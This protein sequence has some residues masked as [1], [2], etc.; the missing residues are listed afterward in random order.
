MSECTFCNE[1]LALNAKFCKF[2]GASQ[3]V[4]LPT[5]SD[6]SVVINEKLTLVCKKCNNE[7]IP[8]AKFCK[9]CGTKVS[10][11]PITELPITELPITELPKAVILPALKH[12]SSS[13]PTSSQTPLKS[14]ASKYV[15]IGTLATVLIAGIGYWG[16]TNK[17]ASDETTLS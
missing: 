3:A 12:V 14:N 5:T 1:E 8:S 6:D 4:K 16:L 7:L 13:P 15:I 10:N 17:K 2:C 11:E 9:V